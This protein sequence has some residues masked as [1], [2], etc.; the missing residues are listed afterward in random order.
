MTTPLEQAWEHY[1]GRLVTNRSGKN[2]A[3]C[4]LHEDQQPSCTVDV[5]EQKWTCHAGCGYGDIYELI[6]LA[7]QR[8]VTFAEAKEIALTFGEEYAKPVTK[9]KRPGRRKPLWVG[10]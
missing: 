10:E 1:G 6:Q 8:T 3:C 4:P 5:K 2:K 7:E 9:K